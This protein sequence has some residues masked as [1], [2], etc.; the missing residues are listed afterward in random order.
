[1]NQMY[2]NDI[3]LM[4][5][6]HSIRSDLDMFMIE[7]YEDYYYTEA[8]GAKEGIFQKIKR[9]IKEIFEKLKAIFRGKKVQQMD[10]SIK[11]AQEAVQHMSTEQKNEKVEVFD[12]EKALKLIEE[13]HEK[14]KKDPKHKRLDKKKLIALCTIPVTMAVAIGILIKNRKALPKILDKE[15]ELNKE[16]EQAE[17]EAEKQV[18]KAQ[19]DA[20]KEVQKQQEQVKKEVQKAQEEIGTNT[21]FKKAFSQGSAMIAHHNDKKSQWEND[22]ITK[23]NDQIKARERKEFMSAYRKG[24]GSHHVKY[25]RN[26]DRTKKNYGNFRTIDSNYKFNPNDKYTIGKYNAFSRSNTYCNKRFSTLN[27]TIYSETTNLFVGDYILI[28]D[29]VS[30]TAKE[31]VEFY[32]TNERRKKAYVNNVKVSFDDDGSINNIKYHSNINN[33]DLAFKTRE[34]VNHILE[35]Y[36]DK[37]AL[38]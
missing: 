38:K 9:K 1:M 2:L 24:L 14:A 12:G 26:E 31:I 17:K 36:K 15:Q 25:W 23:M 6:E 3:D 35:P 20:K 8:E 10:K 13:D 4:K 29:N 19:N 22:Q 33:K 27:S 37:S 16:V 18:E 21:D 11:E 30:K 32:G 34:G 7:C 5:F 28:I